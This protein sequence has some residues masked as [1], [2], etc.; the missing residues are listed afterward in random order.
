MVDEIVELALTSM[1][2]DFMNPIGPVI[3]YVTVLMVT[4]PAPV[5]ATA[6]SPAPSER[7]PEGEQALSTRPPEKAEAMTRNEQPTREFV[8]LDLLSD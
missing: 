6:T 1:G 4:P 7:A 8:T 5:S 2:P 3:E